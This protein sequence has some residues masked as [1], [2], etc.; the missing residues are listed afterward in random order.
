VMTDVYWE[1]F[2]P[3][4]VL[5]AAAEADDRIPLLIERGTPGLTQAFVCEGH[6]CNLPTSDPEV[7][8]AQLSA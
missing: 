6:I 1:R 5:A 4:V 7:L 8:R 2:R 3:Q